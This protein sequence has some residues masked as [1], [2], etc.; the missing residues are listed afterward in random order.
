M[1]SVM[2]PVP[3]APEVKSNLPRVAGA[4]G[5]VVA[6]M[7]MGAFA[8]SRFQEHR[9]A[10]ANEAMTQAAVQF[11]SQ[12]EIAPV[13]FNTGENFLG[14]RVRYL[15]GKITNRS[16]RPVALV[17][18]TFT[19]VDQVGQTVLRE[20]KLIVD[21]H[22]AS[23]RPNETREFAIGFEKMPADWNHQHPAIKITRLKFER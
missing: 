13:F 20:A 15:N 2:T 1:M 23:L 12:I 11:G 7:A 3:E 4:I 17:E 19:F 9:R 18:L 6:L 16:S 5:I 21:E 14:D 10:A 22:K 8:A